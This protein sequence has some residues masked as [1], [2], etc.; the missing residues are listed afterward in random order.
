MAELD[1]ENID[2]LL[3]SYNDGEL[4]INGR[5]YE[6]H[7]TTRSEMMTLAQGV[8][9]LRYFENP[10]EQDIQDNALYQKCEKIIMKNISYNGLQLCKEG[11][12][13]HF[14]EYPQDFLLL[15]TNGWVAL[16]SKMLAQQKKDTS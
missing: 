9:L 11:N 10:G 7:K 12:A 8:G 14:E 16:C 2:V 6:L 1:S 3:Q 15:I 13:D 4:T 5:T